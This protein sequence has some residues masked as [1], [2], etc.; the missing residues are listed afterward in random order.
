MV[1][2][3]PCPGPNDVVGGGVAARDLEDQKTGNVVLAVIADS[4]DGADGAM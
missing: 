3:D 2:M 4:A 1:A